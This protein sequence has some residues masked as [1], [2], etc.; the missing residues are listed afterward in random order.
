MN[1]QLPLAVSL[2]PPASLEDFVAGDND[3]VLAAV[4]RLALEPA[5]QQIYLSGPPGS[6][7]SH[8]LAGAVALAAERGL[9]ALYLPLGELA[10]LSPELLAN[11]DQC[12]LLAIDDLQQAAGHRAW[13]EALFHLYNRARAAET[14]LL[15]AADSGPAAL[16]L[17][18]PDLRSRLAW[19]ASYAL[20]P[21]DDQGRLELL[22]R[23][24]R[25]RGLQLQP[26][27]ARWMVTHCSRDPKRL[28]ALLERLDRLSLA[29]H[30][31]L[32]LPFVR[33]QLAGDAE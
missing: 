14:G 33:D 5:R 13:E 10:P 20:H 18:L 16:D 3:Q 11:L 25:R 21:L 15:F 24:A 1:R 30:R 7:R 12:H 9:Q 17:S 4:R 27:A 28:L 29:Q 19:G 2:S 23:H 31:R 6:G 26:A 8:L 32:T 22:L